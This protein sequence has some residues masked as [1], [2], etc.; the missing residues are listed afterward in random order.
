[1]KITFN[2]FFVLLICIWG[3]STNS[4]NNTAITIDSNIISIKQFFEYH[5]ISSFSTHDQIQKGE[6][7]DDF[8]KKHNIDAR[9]LFNYVKKGNL[10]DRMSFITALVGK[11]NNKFFKMI[12]GRFTESIDESKTKESKVIQMIYK[13]TPKEKKFY[14][15]MAEYEKRIGTREYQMFVG[16]ALRGFGINPRQ[17]KS[18]PEAEEK[19]YQT[20]SK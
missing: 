9:K 11:P 6:I 14:D 5:D 15:K 10:K 17:Y 12:V 20:V 19:L 18:V 13:S 7:V 16:R 2:N 8:I 4:D 1:M 3:C